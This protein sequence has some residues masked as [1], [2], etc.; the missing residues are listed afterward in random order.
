MLRR[1]GA[2]ARRCRTRRCSS[3][4]GAELLAYADRL[5]R[6][7]IP[8]S[9]PRAA[10][11]RRGG[12]RRASARARRRLPGG[13]ARSHGPARRPPLR[14]R[15]GLLERR[16]RRDRRR[17]RGDRLRARGRRGRSAAACRRAGVPVVSGMAMGVDSVAHAGA[18]GGRA[19][20]VAVLATRRRPP[21][22]ARARASCT[23]RSPSAA[24]SSSEMPPGFAP[25]RWAFPARN[26]VIAALSRGHVVVEGG[27]R[28]G[29]LITADFAAE[30]GRFVGAVPARSTAPRSAGPHA[31]L[32]AARRVLVRGR[33]A[34][35]S[36]TPRADAVHLTAGGCRSRRHGRRAVIA[37][38][39][40]L[41]ARP[42]ARS[43]GTE[44]EGRAPRGRP[45]RAR[46]PRPRCAA[47][48]AGA[49]SGRLMR[50]GA[51]PRRPLRVIRATRPVRPQALQVRW[52]N[53]RVTGACRIARRPARRRLRPGVATRR[54]GG[55]HG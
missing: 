14:R 13:A 51:A 11:G 26:R 53:D 3:A 39:S 54:S 6:R 34:I 20:T 37:V 9:A 10:T 25:R 50:G 12:P 49:T 24:A 46:G 4:G 44:E 23:R 22:P 19:P 17:R 2:R 31:L 29:S 48:S 41:G 33:A 8:A 15:P 1:D 18:L 32:K 5:R 55:A 30:L 43:H 45:R 28:S 35:C 47:S 38:R 27:E 7:A 21:V 36:T 16:G 52:R 40:E 42:S